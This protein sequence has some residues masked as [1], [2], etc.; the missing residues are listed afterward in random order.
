[1]KSIK[2]KAVAKWLA[3]SNINTLQKFIG[4]L[5]FYK[6]FIE[7]ISLT[8]RLLHN[9]TKTGTLLAWS[10]KCDEAFTLASIMKISN[11]YKYF[12]LKCSRSDL[13]LGDVLSRWCEKDSELHPVACLF[14]SL[15]QAERITRSFTK[16]YWQF[17]LPPRNEDIT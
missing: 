3:P 1:M 8:T 17:L 5:N 13:A 14:Q 10:R 2:L 6:I 15:I 11:P 9:L 4:F 12:L 16:S 7:H